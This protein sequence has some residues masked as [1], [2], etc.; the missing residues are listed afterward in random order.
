[1]EAEQLTGRRTKRD[2][3]RVGR[4]CKLVAIVRSTTLES[5]ENRLREIAVPGVSVT[6]VK[7]YGEYADFFHPDWMSE[8]A[9]VE[10]ILQRARAR[11]VV[12][13]IMTVARTGAAG[14]GIV[15]VIP[16]DAVHLIRLGR[17]AGV[18]DLGGR[19]SPARRKTIKR[20]KE[21]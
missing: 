2:S 12:R 4:F 3:G 15:I 9:R 14:D 13:A 11:E 1:M 18:N 8:Y 10:I 7:G 6:K 16:V 17:R 19:V 5:V 21:T 20:R